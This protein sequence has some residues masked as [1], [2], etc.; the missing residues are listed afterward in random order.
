MTRSLASN[1]FGVQERMVWEGSSSRGFTGTPIPMKKKEKPLPQYLSVF[2]SL[3][4]KARSYHIPVMCLVSWVWEWG[5]LSSL[6]L[7][8]KIN[9]FIIV[10]LCLATTVTIKMGLMLERHI[11]WH[12]FS[13]WAVW[14]KG[15]ANI[16]E[17]HTRAF[18]TGS[19][20][21]TT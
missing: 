10:T 4:G 3:V 6:C 1:E 9:Y 17:K 2:L 21:G 11:L 16:K 18:A 7:F 13:R 20:A 15:V 14:T 5:W 8:M 19:N 12:W